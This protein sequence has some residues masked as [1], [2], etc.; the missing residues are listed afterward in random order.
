MSINNFKLSKTGIDLIKEFEGEKLEVYKDLTGKLTV[1]I[2]HLVTH[3]DKLKLGQAIT[4]AQSEAFFKADVE[5]FERAVNGSV[6]VAL[7]QNEFDAVVSLAYNVGAN[8][9]RAS[10]S[11]RFY[12]NR[13]RK[14]EFADA[15]LTFNKAMVRG[16][17]TPVAGLT[18]RRLAERK[19]F[20]QK[21]V[22]VIKKTEEPKGE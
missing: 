10:K 19:L 3:R 15:M 6:K 7:T 16:R 12:L 1:G 13:G 17:L 2:G 11:F 9:L 22:K 4:K 14:A 20:L 18:R 21:P 5:E 8:A